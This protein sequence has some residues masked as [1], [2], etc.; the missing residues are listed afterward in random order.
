MCEHHHSPSLPSGWW[1]SPAPSPL[2]SC[3]WLSLCIAKPFRDTIHLWFFLRNWLWHGGQQLAHQLLR[4]GEFNLVS[5][6]A[7]ETHHLSSND[8]GDTATPETDTTRLFLR[9]QAA[10]KVWGKQK[11]SDIQKLYRSSFL[12]NPKGQR[13]HEHRHPKANQGLSI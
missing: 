4:M 7:M 10:A 8:S 9:R 12:P 13:K 3:Y 5:S 6:L 2:L 1:P 11:Q